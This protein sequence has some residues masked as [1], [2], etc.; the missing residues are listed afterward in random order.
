MKTKAELE[1]DELMRKRD[2]LENKLNLIVQKL[3]LTVIKNSILNV[4]SNNTINGR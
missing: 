1:I 3:R 2:E 4:T